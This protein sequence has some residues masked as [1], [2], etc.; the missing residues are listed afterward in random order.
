MASVTESRPN[1]IIL[2]AHPHRL[3]VATKRRVA[4]AHERDGVL[5]LRAPDALDVR[6]SRAMT[7][8]ALWI[9][10]AVLKKTEAAGGKFSITADHKHSTVVTFDGE[11]VEVVLREALRQVPR[12]PSEFEKMIGSLEHWGFQPKGEL[13][14]LLESDYG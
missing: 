2:P 12:P 1:R 9:M 13:L 4:Q 8:R 7:Q 10:D 5:W 14:L 6:V 3:V 11:P